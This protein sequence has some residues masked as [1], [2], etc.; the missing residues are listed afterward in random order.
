MYIMNRYLRKS[1]ICHPKDDHGLNL[2]PFNPQKWANNYLF[3]LLKIL[4][5]YLFYL[6]KNKSYH[7]S[8]QFKHL[9]LISCFY[10]HCC[11]HDDKAHICSSK[12]TPD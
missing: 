10:L 11:R 12:L 9:N 8:L 1:Y 3:Y 7:I 2:F 6:L 4:F 5:I